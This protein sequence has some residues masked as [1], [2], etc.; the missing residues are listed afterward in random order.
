MTGVLRDLVRHL[1]LDASRDVRSYTPDLEEGCEN[2]APF[3]HYGDFPASSAVS[4]P[5]PLPIAASAEYDE[6]ISV[7][8]DVPGDSGDWFARDGPKMKTIVE[9]YEG[10]LRE[11]HGEDLE[12]HS[13]V[14]DVESKYG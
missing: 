12:N 10:E 6:G 4:R 3:G 1:S 8:Q 14:L 11:T 7:M 9:K 2:S 13:V 5:P